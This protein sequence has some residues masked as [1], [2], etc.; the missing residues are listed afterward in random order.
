MAKLTETRLAAYAAE[1]VR[2]ATIVAELRAQGAAEYELRARHGAS[3]G[4]QTERLL[5]FHSE[6]DG[7]IQCVPLYDL[8]RGMT[9]RTFAE[10]EL[11]APGVYECYINSA[12][13]DD[14]LDRGEQ[15]YRGFMNSLSA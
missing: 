5:G 10:I 15:E 6:E 11:V 7:V 2:G 1:A 12:E 13:E 4:A 14:E 9:T 3:Y 8:A